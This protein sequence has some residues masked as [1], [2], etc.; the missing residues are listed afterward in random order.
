MM[1][2]TRCLC[3]DCLPTVIWLAI[4]KEGRDITTGRVGYRD[5]LSHIISGASGASQ[6]QAAVLSER[7]V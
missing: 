1:R 2:G 6:L 5:A 4:S 3:R 7:R